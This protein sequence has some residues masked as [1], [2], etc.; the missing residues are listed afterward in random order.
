MYEWKE[1]DLTMGRTNESDA[2]LRDLAYFYSYTYT[3]LV[4]A[5]SFNSEYFIFCLW[6]KCW[7]IFLPFDFD[8][9]HSV[10]RREQRGRRCRISSSSAFSSTFSSTQKAGNDLRPFVDALL[11]R[12][13]FKDTAVFLSAAAFS[14]ASLFFF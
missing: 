7:V 13:C 10:L 6:R 3:I 8:D 11:N 9:Y 12:N 5:N 2:R 1:K 4:L 14:K